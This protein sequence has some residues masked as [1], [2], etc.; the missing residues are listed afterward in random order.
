MNP[1]GNKNRF[2]DH[3]VIGA[4]EKAQQGLADLT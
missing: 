4:V 3:R 1:D 2:R